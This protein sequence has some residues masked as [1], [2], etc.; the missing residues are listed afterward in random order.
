M[1]FYFWW[2]SSSWPF[3][4]NILEF[5]SSDFS[6]SCLVDTG[7][8]CP[9]IFYWSLVR[10]EPSSSV[11]ARETAQ[12]MRCSSDFCFFVNPFRDTNAKGISLALSFYSFLNSKLLISFIEKRDALNSFFTLGTRNAEL[13]SPYLSVMKCSQMWLKHFSWFISPAMSAGVMLFPDKKLFVTPY[14][15]SISVKV[16]LPR[17][18]LLLKS[19]TFILC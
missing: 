8:L 15:S 16:L 1:S 3:F 12:Y 4:S 18:F 6:L 13:I 2:L 9:S 5:L 7:L 10:D 11:F 17:N 14:F 19:R